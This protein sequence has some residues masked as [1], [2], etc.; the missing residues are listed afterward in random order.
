MITETYYDIANY[1]DGWW[2]TPIRKGLTHY[3]DAF[4]K[5]FKPDHT[6]LENMKEA[7]HYI[8]ERYPKSKLKLVRKTETIEYLDI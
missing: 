7:L 1:N 2:Y 6:D 3:R 8:R 5:G 4:P